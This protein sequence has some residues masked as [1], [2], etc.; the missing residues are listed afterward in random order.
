ML[1][2]CGLGDTRQEVR[3]KLAPFLQLFNGTVRI[4]PIY[5]SQS[6]SISLAVPEV[7]L[8]VIELTVECIM[9]C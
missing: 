7:H 4:S 3:I 2:R 8:Y 5:Y 9:L 6:L 1:E